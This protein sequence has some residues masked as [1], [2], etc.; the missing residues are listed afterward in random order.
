MNVRDDERSIR[1]RAMW[2]LVALAAAAMA[3]FATVALSGSERDTNDV[4]AQGE[5][6]PTD[7]EE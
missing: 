5:D 7:Q 6:E 2:A 1:S 4:S 3:T